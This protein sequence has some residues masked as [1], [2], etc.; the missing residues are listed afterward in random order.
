MGIWTDSNGQSWNIN[1]GGRALAEMQRN[2]NF[3][4]CWIKDT[5]GIDDESDSNFYHE[6]EGEDEQK[7]QGRNK[8]VTV[9]CADGST[10]TGKVY[11]W[12]NGVSH[13][14]SLEHWFILCTKEEH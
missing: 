12:V 2:P 11:H 5:P 4:F 14:C 13:N 10:A 3:K 1:I 9:N 6:E 8:V 7:N